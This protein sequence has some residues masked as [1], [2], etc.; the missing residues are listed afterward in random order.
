MG[1]Y[2]DGL[3]EANKE[4]EKSVA[5]SKQDL[6]VTKQ[7]LTATQKIAQAFRGSSSSQIAN[8]SSTTN[9]TANNGGGNTNGYSGA[10]PYSADQAGPYSGGSASKPPRMSS[11]HDWGKLVGGAGGMAMGIVSM[12]PTVEEAT[13]T[14][15]IKSRMAFYND[16]SSPYFKGGHPSGFIGPQK[17]VQTNL[18]YR[19]Q[20][21][22]S[23]MG[24]ALTPS[25]AMA[26]INNGIQMGFLPSMDNYGMGK[27][28]GANLAK[29]G[30]SGILGGAALASNLSPGI[31]LQG[32]MAAMGS[33]NQAQNVNMLK[34]LGVQ[35]RNSKGTGMNDL[36]E[37][38]EQI[39]NVL[40]RGGAITVKDIAG[41]LMPGNALDSFLNQ[42]LGGDPNLKNVVI[43]GLIQRVKG[44]SSLR[45]TG[46]KDALF[47]TGGLTQ[48][49]VSQGA[50]STA[51][52]QLIQSYADITTGAAV[53]ANNTLTRGYNAL[54]KG[55]IAGSGFENLSRSVFERGQ[56][57]STKLDLFAG[58]RN[59]AGQAIIESA[60]KG[61]GGVKGPL[62]A[63][64]GIGGI[65]TAFNESNQNPGANFLNPVSDNILSNNQ[66]YGPGQYASASNPGQV[67]TGA[68][69]VNVA[70]PP[71]QDP[72]SY[73]L[74]IGQAMT[75]RS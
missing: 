22:L 10:N 58:A 65:A 4:K 12:L 23:N 74:A 26:A 75:A 3:K 50:R 35:V 66:G 43:S 6:E 45:S 46:T 38:I 8:H 29:T 63:L 68:I 14:Q 34:M 54:T 71:G 25:D 62:K 72:Y 52:L 27:T 9:G 28:G 44:G 21:D 40:A 49:V 57:L 36:P 2:V 53:E 61:M 13:T 18:G 30:F 1:D 17:P 5:L 24:T 55:A 19:M 59:N 37:I 69:T 51:E 56:V 70:A 33:L 7:T 31:G 20:R 64:I 39:Y 47:N 60:L 16:G 41:S 73:G 32:G 15:L 42:Y 67:Y 48:A 11:G